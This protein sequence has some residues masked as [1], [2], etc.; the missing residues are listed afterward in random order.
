MNQNDQ[1]GLFL[2]IWEDNRYINDYIYKKKNIKT[3]EML[4][5][6]LLHFK[7]TENMKSANDNNLLQSDSTTDLQA[8]DTTMVSELANGAGTNAGLISNNTGLKLK[9]FDN[10][11]WLINSNDVILN[12]N[13]NLLILEISPNI[14]IP[15][16]LLIEL[17]LKDYQVINHENEFFNDDGRDSKLDAFFKTVNV[18]HHAD[19]PIQDG[20]KKLRLNFL[21]GC[22]MVKIFKIKFNKLERLMNLIE[23][24]RNWALLNNLIRNLLNDVES[25][26]ESSVGQGIGG[27]VTDSGSSVAEGTRRGTKGSISGV[28]GNI[29]DKLNSTSTG[30]T[31]PTDST[32]SNLD[33][34]D[35][36]RLTDIIKENAALLL[37]TVTSGMG[38]QQQN[39]QQH[40]QKLVARSN[41]LTS[42]AEAQL[43]I[44]IEN[45]RVDEIWL[46]STEYL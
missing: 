36:L 35:D 10:G 8:G 42:E 20:T 37:N 22:E 46:V 7:I 45:L 9:W 16:D 27:S 38:D 32:E 40:P 12:S 25:K 2:K 3:N 19:I 43:Y 24:L 39:A 14:W 6:Y 34:Q 17:N 31:N 13:L 23:T 15:Q 44:T 30:M 5:P 29:K 26:E 41:S 1:I 18:Q 28:K 21:T 4:N 33:F 11:D